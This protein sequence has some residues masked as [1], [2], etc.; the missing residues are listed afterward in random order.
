ML[1]VAALGQQH[2]PAAPMRQRREAARLV[3]AVLGFQAAQRSLQQRLAR[4]RAALAWVAHRAMP[5]A[6][7]VL[8]QAAEVPLARPPMTPMAAGQTPLVSR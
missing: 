8:A 4:Q 6:A 5:L 1:L 7:G 3:F 2:A